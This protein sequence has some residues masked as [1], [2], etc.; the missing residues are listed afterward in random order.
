M[1]LLATDS[2]FPQFF[3][4]DG[5]PL[6]EGSIYYGLANQN[7]VTAQLQVYWDT[8]ATQPVAQPVKTLNGYPVRFGTP[9]NV[10]TDQIYSISVYDK[11]GR[12]IYTAPSSTDFSQLPLIGNQTD[13]N[14]GSA[15]IGYLPPWTGA[16]GQTVSQRLQEYVSAQEFGLKTTNTGAQ[17]NTAM[18]LA[19]A[20]AVAQGGL[21]LH[22]P[23][24]TYSFASTID[25]SGANNLRITGDGIDST[26]LQITS[27]TVDF[28]SA[29]GTTNY[30]TIDNL[31]LTSS[32]PRTAGAMFK[33]GFWKRG[34]MYRVKISKHFDGINMFSFEVCTISETNIVTPTGA[35][36]AIKIGN[37]AAS[38]QGANLTIIDCFIRGNDETVPGSTQ[39]G[40]WGF[41][42]YDIEAIF[43]INT[44]IG[45]VTD[46]CMVMEPTFATK[47]CYFTSVY[48]DATVSG[49]N[50]LLKGA[51]VKTNMT[52][53]G[54][55]FATAG[56]AVLPGV[57]NQAG[58]HVTN[59]GSYTDWN[60]VGCRFLATSGPGILIETPEAD[61]NFT[62]CNFNNCG[63]NTTLPTSV[64][65]I[66]GAVQ[67]K[68]ALFTGCLIT[69]FGTSTSDFNF[70]N[71]N[72]VGNILTGN[73]LQRGIAYAAG[74]SFG[75]VS[76]N[77]DV[78]TTDVIASAATLIV[79]PTKNFYT[80]TG[81]TNVGGLV[82]TFTG[83]TITFVA[84][85]AFTWQNGGALVL[86][87]GGNF[88]TAAGSTITLICQPSGA[89][90]R[91]IS[92]HT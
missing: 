43:C 74:S 39:V 80:I 69:P 31:T 72:C 68:A 42:V 40:K 9:A 91:E 33:V 87:G 89:V 12:L 59:T 52:F 88:V 44:D 30:Q 78:N 63:A 90:W 20:Y 35:G 45:A 6:D 73:E 92:R 26:I 5:D 48:F 85:G 57:A 19:V 32:V 7:P 8:A 58:L 49:D 67:T 11:K 81:T 22:I 55:W 47:N 77:S 41:Y 83:H 24:G 10:F 23:R 29:G 62:G 70:A 1:T 65:V 14:L 25:T 2:P 76:G 53:N 64:Y 82:R 38:N 21:T 71:T 84:T 4:F 36:T 66:P 13:P 15:L 18:G 46:N 60:F 51:G 61:F 54:C 79:S 3:D 56:R 16:V 86:A 17:N 34:L 28:I 50:V 75:S 27:G 37:P